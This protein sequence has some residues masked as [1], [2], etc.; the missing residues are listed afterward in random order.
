MSYVDYT[1]AL[2]GIDFSFHLSW[3]STHGRKAAG[4][5]AHSGSCGGAG[6]GKEAAAGNDWDV[7]QVMQRKKQKESGFMRISLRSFSL[8]PY[9][10]RITTGILC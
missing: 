4:C 9:A 7:M 2:K 3:C 6:E 5:A 1:S 10:L 8:Q